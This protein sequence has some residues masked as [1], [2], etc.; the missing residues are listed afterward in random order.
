ML[1]KRIKSKLYAAGRVAK[2]AAFGSIVGAAIQ[3]K[4]LKRKRSDDDDY[5][6]FLVRLDL[7][8]TL[9]KEIIHAAYLHVNTAGLPVLF[10][11][12]QVES[13]EQKARSIWASEIELVRS[14]EGQIIH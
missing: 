5:L 2:G 6:R 9:L 3:I 11:D 7:S 13:W 4:T 10:H 1:K 14:E 8:A 12:Q